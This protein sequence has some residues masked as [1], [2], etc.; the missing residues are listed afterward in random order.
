M[1]PWT[2]FDAD[3]GYLNQNGWQ[4]VNGASKAALNSATHSII[5]CTGRPRSNAMSFHSLDAWTDDKAGQEQQHHTPPIKT[6]GIIKKDDKS[7]EKGN[8]SGARFVG[9]MLDG[10]MDLD[11]HYDSHDEQTTSSTESAA[12]MNSPSPDP[13]LSPRTPSQTDH[14]LK[15]VKRDRTTAFGIADSEATGVAVAIRFQKV[16]G[17][18]KLLDLDKTAEARLAM[19]PDADGTS[20]TSGQ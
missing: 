5:D 6:S 10:L 12:I 1:I 19:A 16:N 14:P 7:W 3:N 11:P 8:K 9:W 13:T 15:G 18:A 2:K 4:S 20:S 17:E